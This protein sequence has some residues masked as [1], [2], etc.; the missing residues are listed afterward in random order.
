MMEIKKQY[1]LPA[2]L[3]FA[4][5]VRKNSLAIGCGIAHEELSTRKWGHW[6]GMTPSAVD[7]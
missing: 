5:V 2:V 7:S 1:L 6:S 4:F 3:I